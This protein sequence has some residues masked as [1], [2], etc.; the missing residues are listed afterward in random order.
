V[1]KRS[2]FVLFV[3]LLALATT[4]SAQI[5][6]G[7]KGGVNL[8]DM[9]GDGWVVLAAEAETTVDHKFSLGFGG[10][11]FAQV[12]LGQSGLLL[13]PEALFIVKGYKRETGGSDITH[14]AKWN[15]IEVPV[16]VKYSIPMQGKISPNLFAGPFAAF[17]IGGKI[18]FGNIPASEEDGYEYLDIDNIKALDFGI[19]FGGG[20]DFAV[21][22]AGKLTFDVRYTMG[23]T[24]A[25]DDVTA[26]EA[27]NLGEN[28]G[29]LVD[30]D[31]RGLKLENSDIRFMVGY[32]F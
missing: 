20:L 6:F 11:V 9:A 15:Y 13:Q 3:L 4:A 31:R 22:P 12:P 7:L 2:S 10:G 18:T 19:T 24:D 14:T 27:A 32:A 16:L 29:M 28:T 1:K 8:A 30:D 17:N 21:G 25:F 23:L 26:E 5:K